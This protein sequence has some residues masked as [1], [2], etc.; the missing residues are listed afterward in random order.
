MRRPK[1]ANDVFG[2]LN[3]Q[4]SAEI[5]RQGFHKPTPIQK[6]SIPRILRGESVLLIA[7]T[8]HGKTE[9]AFLPRLHHILTSPPAKEGI[10]LLWITPLRALNRDILRRLV[11]IANNL[12][13]KADV[14]HGDTRA[15]TRR[16]QMLEPP[17][18]LVTTPESLQAILTGKK[19]R[20]TLRTIQCVVIDEIHELASSKRGV[21]LMVGLE[22]LRELTKVPFQRIGL[23]ATVGNPEEIRDFM[24]GEKKVGIIKSPAEK[25]F[26]FSLEY[27]P[28]SYGD[29]EKA[30]LDGP[31]ERIW[32]LVS[33]HSSTLIFCNERQTAEALALRLARL[34]QQESGVHHGSL[35]RE[36]RIDAEQRFKGG[37]TP[38]LVCTS[39]LELGLDIG[40]VDL[41]IQY[42][43]PRQVIR[44]VQRVGRAGHQLGRKAKG[45]I[46][47]TKFD[48]VCEGIVVGKNALD[49]C[50][51]TPPVHH[52]ALDI[53]AH[54]LVGLAIEYKSLTYEQ[55]TELIK[56]AA[57]Y[58][59]L[60]NE[61]IAQVRE[62]LQKEGLISRDDVILRPRRK[63]YSY[64]FENLSVIPDIPH[65]RVINVATNRPVGRLDT[66]FAEEYGQTGNI[67]VLRGRPW[68][69]VKQDEESVYVTAIH[70]TKGR[71]P[72]WSGELIPVSK[73]V[74]EGVSTLWNHIAQNLDHPEALSYE[75]TI[76]NSAKE[77]QLNTIRKQTQSDFIPDNRTLII[78]VGYELIV[79][80]SSFGT[81][82]NQTLGRLLAALLTSQLGRDIVFHADQYRILF[83]FE[84]GGAYDIADALKE[85][86][87]SL[88]PNHMDELLELILLR[89]PY[90]AR[91][92]LHVARRFGVIS[93]SANLG[94][95]QLLRIMQYFT[96]TPIIDEAL[97]EFYVDKLDIDQTRALLEKIQTN[98]ITVTQLYR[99]QPSPFARQILARFGEFLEPEIPE[100]YILEQTKNR[101]LNRKVRLVCL[102]CGQWSSVRTIKH[103]D[104]RPQCKKCASKHVAGVFPTDEVLQK[105]IR[106]H[107]AGIKLSPEEKKALRKGR[108][109][110]EVVLNYGKPAIIA[111][112][113]RGIGPTVVK[114]ILAGSHERPESE[115]YRLILESEKQFI[116]T[117]EWWAESKTDL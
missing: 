32:E 67:L 101:L 109:N 5:T 58:Q 78:E 97:R 113:G 37:E 8:G 73:M 115:F 26:Q 19:I 43:S 85:G 54:Q 44:L 61:K 14:R 31:A 66:G 65:H 50:L 111:M 90:F 94:S 48:D 114:R 1:V 4:L 102:H 84:R 83:R 60:E 45:V 9:A 25:K 75:I 10:N 103:L 15:S 88:D 22:R 7:P 89:S 20:E 68:E 64:Y 110:A 11:L 17:L 46:L 29:E 93:K 38:Y 2:Q 6:R 59:T 55:A 28:Y 72:R 96:G 63:S 79:I 47:T 92:F 106:R 23:S 70:Q 57:P 99:K 3:S 82:I 24:G 41:V 33:K 52:N 36:A 30:P 80:H 27:C 51:E 112:A 81:R 42:G 74:A 108:E 40:T 71:I 98:E 69:V 107:R 49:G 105:A 91:R 13:I 53:V 35:S 34:H 77:V 86:F 21:Q 95:S 16:R 116:R 87:Q 12:E 76:D 39:S 62:C 18:I 117:R 104:E 56:R 100:A